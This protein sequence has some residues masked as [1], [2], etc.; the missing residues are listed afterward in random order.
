MEQNEQNPEAN[1]GAVRLS[2]PPDIYAIPLAVA[3][4]VI[5]GIFLHFISDAFLTFVAALFLA[6]IFMPL[7]ALLQKKK[8]PMVLVILL[9]LTMVATV[10]FGLVI[11]IASSIS[12]VIEVLPHY[13]QRWDHVLLPA[14][15]ELLNRV[16]PD[17]KDQ[18]VSF[19]FSSLFPAGKI[20]GALSSITGL[21]SSSALILLFMLFILA[22]HGA[23]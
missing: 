11:V 18:V 7:V 22:S 13:Q 21:I 12:S 19:N 2:K 15:S 17:L 20:V 3:A 10:L 23:F 8:V 9:V 16:S 5:V 6:N 1:V 14:L 4:V